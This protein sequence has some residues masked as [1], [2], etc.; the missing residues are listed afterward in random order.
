MK[1]FV[2]I[3]CFL[4]LVYA[5]LMAAQVYV[6]VQQQRKAG[7]SEIN[8]TR[9]R[10]AVVNNNYN[11]VERVGLSGI[12]CLGVALL[13]ISGGI[14]LSIGSVVGLSATLLAMLLRKDDFGWQPTVAIPAVLLM[15][16]LVGLVN[17]LLVTKVKVQAFVV[18]L[19][20]LFVYRGAAR[21][22][23]GDTVKG[24]GVDHD[25]LREMLYLN[26]LGGVPRSLLYL[27]VL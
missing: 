8:W 7:A 5:V 11:L 4:V 14:D 22:L 26:D 10:T 19:C 23:A 9:V 25:P 3:F 6:L 13:I 17:G 16:A 21:W 24:L 18:T 20:G 2:G 1:K 27:L 12:I 15:G